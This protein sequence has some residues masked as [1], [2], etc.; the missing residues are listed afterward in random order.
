[1]YQKRRNSFARE[2]K[3]STLCAKTK[4]IGK[5]T[6]KMNEGLDVFGRVF[7]GIIFTK[8]V[9]FGD[10]VSVVVFMVVFKSLYE[11]KMFLF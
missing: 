4:N 3:Q 11:F 1:M 9:S 5:I 10:K 7:F 8:I 6:K 2:N